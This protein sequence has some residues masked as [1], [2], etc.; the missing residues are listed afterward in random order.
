MKKVVLLL[1]LAISAHSLYSCKKEV[2]KTSEESE[3]DPLNIPEAQLALAEEPSETVS[4][5]IPYKYVTALSGLSLREFN[6]LQSKKVGKMPYGSKVKV[7]HSESKNTMNVSGIHGAMDEIEFNHKTGFAFN[8]YLSRYFP[9]ERDMHAK[10]YAEELQIHFPEVQFSEVVKGTVSKPITIETL[11]LPKAQ[12]HEAFFMAQQLF[13][14]PSEFQFPQSEGKDLEVI[15]DQKPKKDI[16]ESRLEITRKDDVLQ[17][18]EYLYSSKKFKAQVIVEKEGAM[19][20]LT[21]IE[22]LQ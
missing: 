3:T 9:P 13:E 4:T 6:N 14:I 11:S 10:A 2:S 15:Q 7:I 22:S 21:K 17:K 20:K 12:W 18:I 16:W 1:V 19:M 5:S 8:G